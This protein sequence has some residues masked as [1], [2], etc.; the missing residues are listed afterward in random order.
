MKRL[1]IV[2]QIVDQEDPVLGFFT[3]WIEKLAPS[4]AAVEVVCLAEGRHSLPANVRVRS[5]GKEKGSRSR[6]AYAF[7]FL[8]LAWSLR[9]DYD[10]VFVHMNQEYVLLGGLLWSVLGKP[11]FMWRNHGSGSLL[12]RIAGAFCRAVF[13]TSRASYTAAFRNAVIMPVGV[14]LARFE[15]GASAQRVPGSILMAGRIAPK[16]RVREVV[17]ALVMLSQRGMHPTLTLVGPAAPE[18]E[19]YRASLIALASAAGIGLSLRGGVPHAELPRIF[20]EHDIV[21]NASEPGMFDKTMLEALASGCILLTSHPD[22]RRELDP[23]QFFDGVPDLSEKLRAMLVLDRASR[24]GLVR[25]GRDAANRHSLD[26]LVARLAK[27][28]YA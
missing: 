5:L 13:A 23:R 25:E 21:V 7:R 18:H 10:A 24:D 14:D 2:T 4:F 17:E 19:A 6:A 20:A 12:T 8:H 22:L 15:G 3:R 28:L 11:V 9:H 27:E 26:A 16:K 1:L